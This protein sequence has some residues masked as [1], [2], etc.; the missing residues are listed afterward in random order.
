MADSDVVTVVGGVLYLAPTTASAPT[1]AV[2]VLASPWVSLGAWA[3]DGATFT[4]VAGDVTEIKNHFK[5]V[6][7]RQ[8]ETGNYTLEF[9]FIESTKDVFETYFDTTVDEDGRYVLGAGV[10]NTEYSLVY[11]KVYSDGES[12]RQYAAIA[13]VAERAGQTLSATEALTYGMTF[14]TRQGDDPEDGQIV[15]F[16]PKFA[17]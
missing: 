12:E 1:S 6:V 8:E 11:D 17:A 2:S 5:R 13:Y 15:G 9:P 16:A 10:M 3:E 7:I 14:G 4:P